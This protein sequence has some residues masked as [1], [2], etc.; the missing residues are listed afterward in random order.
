M[1]VKADNLRVAG[2]GAGW[3]HGAIAD[4]GLAGGAGSFP[5]Q[6]LVGGASYTSPHFQGRWMSQGLV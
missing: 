1:S 4:F 3:S 5:K 2:A 6:F